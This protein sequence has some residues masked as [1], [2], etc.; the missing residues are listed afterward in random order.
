MEHLHPTKISDLPNEMLE[1]IFNFLQ[2]PDDFLSVI[3]TCHRWNDLMSYRKT[4]RLFG[5]VLPI[6]L[7]SDLVPLRSMLTI[8]LISKNWKQAAEF[9]LEEDPSK[10]ER[11]YDVVGVERVNRFITHAS[12]LP[13]GGNPF[14][15]KHLM[16]SALVPETYDSIHQLIQQHGTLLRSIEMYFYTIIQFTSIVGAIPNLE[17]LFIWGFIEVWDIEDEADAHPFPPLLRLNNLSLCLYGTAQ[18]DDDRTLRLLS[19]MLTAYGEQLTTL[20]CPKQLLRVGRIN[21]LRNL[22]RLELIKANALTDT[23][24]LPDFQVLSQV[25]WRLHTLSLSDC[26]IQFTAELMA[27]LNNFCETLENLEIS[28]ELEEN[29]DAD[30]LASFPFLKKLDLGIASELRFIPL[31]MKDALIKLSGVSPNL[32]KLDICLRNGALSH[33]FWNMEMM[34]NVFRKL[35]AFKLRAA[36]YPIL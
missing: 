12:N 8:R 24:T 32:E 20:K 34:I 31:G 14:I 33:V 18:N 36:L 7:K 15:G 27:A 9:Q 16:I 23:Y 21:L 5:K 17:T 6:L 30:S 29:F 4:E 25:K 35:N 2:D 19:L 28:I 1:E 13:Q 26:C 22:R 3:G 10:L 11:K